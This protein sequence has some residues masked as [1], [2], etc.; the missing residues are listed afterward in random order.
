MK[1]KPTPLSLAVAATLG[2]ISFHTA[3]QTTDAA[4]PAGRSVTALEEIVVTARRREESL[5]AVPISITAIGGTAIERLKLEQPEDLQFQVPSLMVQGSQDQVQMSIRG[6][7]INDTL[8]TT[9]APVNIYFGEALVSRPM[10]TNQ[11]MYDLE[12]V[13]VLKGVQGTLF[14]RNSTGG[15]LI[16]KPAAPSDVFEGYVKGSLGNYDHREL[17]GMV[18]LPMGDTL[19]LRVAGKMLDRDGFGEN[20]NTGQEVEDKDMEAW[21][22]SL[23]WNPTDG[24]ES[25]TIYD[26]YRHD[27]SSSSAFTMHEVSFNAPAMMGVNGLVAAAQQ[28][29][30]FFPAV[31]ENT[32]PANLNT[33]LAEQ[34]AR[35]NPRDFRSEVGTGAPNQDFFGEFYSKSQNWGVQ[36]ITSVEFDS[37]T[38][39]NIA[40]YREME[41]DFLNDIDGSPIPMIAFAQGGQYDFF[42]E[43]LQ[44][45][46]TALDDK[47]DW[48]AGLYY[49]K[50]DGDDFG[51]SNAF[52]IFGVEGT[53]FG[54][55]GAIFNGTNAQAAVNTANAAAAQV[56][57]L[58]MTTGEVENTAQ[59][60]YLGL[61]YRF[62]DSWTLAT[63]LRYNEDKRTYGATSRTVNMATGVASCSFRVDGV[64]LPIEQCDPEVSETFEELTY[65][66]TLSYNLSSDAMV[67]G[68][69]RHGYRAG[70]F[71]GRGLNFEQLA[72]YNPEL[73]DEFE[74]GFKTDFELGTMPVRANGAIFY[75]DYQDIQR[76]VN[77]NIGTEE[78]PQVST[79]IQNAANGSIR[80]GELELEFRPT[81]YASLSLFYSYLD[82]EFDDYIDP[83]TGTDLSDR[84]LV[85]AAKHMGGATLNLFTDLGE[86]GELIWTMNVYTQ[87]KQHL[88]EQDVAS[89]ES[90][91]SL[92]NASVTWERVADS[93]FDLRLWAKNLA[94]KEYRTYS[95]S[96]LDSPGFAGVL[97]GAPRTYGLDLV[98]RFG[99]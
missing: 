40:S 5:Q 44:F 2:A 85:F 6:Q 60:V 55:F 76:Q 30:P 97:W 90:G 92:I 20:L 31:A 65:D 47:L 33:L 29:A 3:A 45:L 37:F 4:L 15:A 12:Q 36:N 64:P 26:H 19:A 51:N 52:N 91:Y 21:R 25:N 87:S 14:G 1:I 18:N 73:V 70:G 96:L 58:G 10:G 54:T 7:F 67:Y 38:V 88:D 46:G 49:M 80:G 8:G 98:Y 94:D 59:A 86:M 24:V 13:Q 75:Q 48:I 68:A 81:D 77:V 32:F 95:V 84:W 69:F 56:S 83:A 53:R 82:G 71:N 17:Q 99:K 62:N 50:E 9:D 66:A 34:R 43:E 35:S 61:T 22:I 23:K 42:S 63:G 27:Q 39:K 72:P 89:D 78:A 57:T 16:L 74:L 93:G 28:L 79:V 41:L 11:S